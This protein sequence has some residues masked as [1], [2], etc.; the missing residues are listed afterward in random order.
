MDCEAGE[1]VNSKH[2][3]SNGMC[4]MCPFTT[5]LRNKLKIHNESKHECVRYGCD[6]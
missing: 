1:H 6:Q 5:S 3:K 2:N 4:D